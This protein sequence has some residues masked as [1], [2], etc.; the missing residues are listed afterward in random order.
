MLVDELGDQLLAG[1]A[2]AMDHHRGV[3]RRDFPRQLDGFAEGGRYAEERDPVA[4]ARL[5]HGLQ[6]ELIRLA[7]AENRVHG[8]AEQYFQMRRREG[9][10]EVVPCPLLQSLD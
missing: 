5:A 2:L 3:R 6:P 9:L 8:P 4:V 1:S 7:R 10:R